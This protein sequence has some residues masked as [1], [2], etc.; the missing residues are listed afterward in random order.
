MIEPRYA[1]LRVL[2]EDRVF[3]IP[4]Y[5]RFYSWQSR[6]REDLF[7]DLRNLAAREDDEHH[8]MATLVCHRTR[9]VEP[10]GAAAYRVFDLVDGQQRLTTLVLILKSIELS[11][12]E[13]AAERAELAQ[14]IVKPDGNLVLLQANNANERLFNAY[15]RDGRHPAKQDIRTHADR[16]LWDAVRECGAFVDEWRARHGELATLRRLVLNRLGFVVYETAECRVVYGL[17][18]VLNSRGLEVDWLDKCKSILMGR[19][20]DLAGSAVVAE[21]AIQALQNIWGDIYR[22][23]AQARVPGQEIVRVAATLAYGE[24]KG[25]PRSADESLE[26][27]SADCDHLDKPRRIAERL[28]DV[29]HKLVALERNRFLGPVTRVLQA[30]ILAVALESADFLSEPQ[31]RRV[32]DQ[33]ERVTF[34]IFGLCGKDARTKVGEYVRL[35]SRIMQGAPGAASYDEVMPALRDLGKDYTIDE[36]VELVSDPLWYDYPEE[37]RYFLWRYEEHLARKAGRGATVDEQARQDV[38]QL[39]ATDSVEHIL[40]RNPEP[41]GPWRG[42][43]RRGRFGRSRDHWENVDRIGNLILLPIDLNVEARR[44][45]FAEK[46]RIYRRHQLRMIKEVVAQS[47]WTLAQIDE[48]EQ[49]L[50]EWARTEWDDLPEE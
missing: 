47:D 49:K 41:D 5:Q 12:P 19:A 32:L 11:L 15:L 45:G 1:T 14:V 48:R 24:A 31:L 6:Q 4:Q 8:F 27:I 22:Q 28:L 25:K 9:E 29:T 3:R 16:N 23:I 50:A 46:K 43:M 17:F 38:W 7:S 44:Q 40:P 2:L 33:W 13:D 10:S 36:A 35:A 18:E 37:C 20:F 39:R 21:A 30:R 34:R 42:K 26:L